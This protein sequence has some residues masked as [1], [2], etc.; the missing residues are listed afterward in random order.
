MLQCIP[1]FT[2]FS[3]QGGHPQDTQMTKIII[4]ITI[5]VNCIFFINFY[6]VLFSVSNFSKSL[7]FSHTGSQIKK[8]V[9]L[10]L[11]NHSPVLLAIMPVTLPAIGCLMKT[12]N[13]LKLDLFVSPNFNCYKSYCNHLLRNPW[14]IIVEIKI[15]INNN[16]SYTLVVIQCI[17]IVN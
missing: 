12:V 2:E 13:E 14:F 4:I 7:N 11:T 17:N 9:W 6:L 16:D 8:K 3:T 5:I 1:K 10:T 15:K